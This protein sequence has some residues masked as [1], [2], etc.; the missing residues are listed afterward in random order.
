MASTLTSGSYVLAAAV[1]LV[2][3]G[4]TFNTNE[5]ATSSNRPDTGETGWLT[6]PYCDQLEMSIKKE[7]KETFAPVTGHRVRTAVHHTQSSVEF[8]GTFKHVD[9]RM[10]Q[11]AFGA[12]TIDGTDDTFSPFSATS[13]KMAWVEFKLY[14][15]TNTLIGTHIVWCRVSVVD[16][17]TMGENEIQATLSMPVI[18]NTLND[19]DLL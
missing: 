8:K 5:T 16:S 7:F 19:T 6:L 4:G 12:A 11:M 15:S 3:D 17:I 14:D 9:C 18:Y 10:L 2:W 13:D 1:R